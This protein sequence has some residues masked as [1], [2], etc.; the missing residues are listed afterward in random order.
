MRAKGEEV[1]DIRKETFPP[2]NCDG[3]CPVKVNAEVWSRISTTAR[4]RD[5]RMQNVGNYIVA[6]ATHL[7]HLV[8]DLNKHWDQETGI[9]TPENARVIFYHANKALRLL[10]E[11]T[12]NY[13]CGGARRSEQK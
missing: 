9:L 10:G 5:L 8:D 1:E 12:M 2:A 7:S 4:Q 11:Q 13:K 6:G 3:L